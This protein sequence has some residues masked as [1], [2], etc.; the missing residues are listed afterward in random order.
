MVHSPHAKKTRSSA[1]M[2]KLVPLTLRTPDKGVGTL[3]ATNRPD[4][5]S[6]RNFHVGYFDKFTLPGER[7]V[8]FTTFMDAWHQGLVNARTPLTFA[9]NHVYGV[10]DITIEGLTYPF[11][12]ITNVDHD[13]R[14]VVIGGLKPPRQEA[15]AAYPFKTHPQGAC[16]CGLCTNLVEYL[17]AG[18]EGKQRTGVLATFGNKYAWMVN[19]FPY[20][21]GDSLVID[22]NHDDMTHR[23]EPVIDAAGIKRLP[24]IE[25]KTREALLTEEYVLLTMHLCDKYQQAAQRNHAIDGKSQAHDHFKLCPEVHPM[26]S[27]KAIIEKDKE[28]AGVVTIYSPVNT[29]FDTLAL[30]SPNRKMLAA[31]LVAL[32]N[33]LERESEVYTLCYYQG[34]WLISP[35]FKEAMGDS[36]C[37]PRGIGS[38]VGVHVV[39]NLE[40]VPKYL[41]R[42]LA[43]IPTKN[44]FGWSRYTDAMSAAA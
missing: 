4:R 41:E 7:P 11:T 8:P 1:S 10:V 16:A 17:D 24:I 31:K 5:A 2:A 19:R 23:V 12:T 14:A 34:H 40:T 25:G 27:A 32:V 15:L 28:Y 20:N 33:A 13:A 39:E 21:V 44:K 43:I 9:D 3:F 35:R 36:V 30:T 42:V 29:P 26:H 37:G 18:V 38:N 22:M 6:F